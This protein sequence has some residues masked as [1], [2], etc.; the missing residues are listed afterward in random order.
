MQSPGLI[1]NFVDSGLYRLLFCDICLDGEHMT[2]VLLGN[3]GEL[4]AWIA[5]VDGIDLRGSIG[6]TAVCYA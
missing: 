5:N 4:I 2:W 1:Q 6:K 3:S